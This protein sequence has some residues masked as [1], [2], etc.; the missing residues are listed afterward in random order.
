MNELKTLA[1]VIDDDLIGK[2]AKVVGGEDAVK[3]VMFLRKEGDATND[4][5]QEHTGLTL[6]DIRK[7][8]FKLY[9]HSL[10]QCD[11]SRDKNTGWFVFHW[12]LQ[13]DQIEGFIKNMKNRV[14]GILKMRLEYEENNDFFYCYTPGC[15]RYAFEEAMELVFRCP[16]CG[17]HLQHYDNN[18][19]IEALRRKIAQIERN[20]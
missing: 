8:L 5:I 6:N 7:I 19:I 12:R 16:V 2:V 10:V 13:Q 18:K 4:Q 11:R 15:D 3:I 17:K 9:N 1:A 14:L 20:F